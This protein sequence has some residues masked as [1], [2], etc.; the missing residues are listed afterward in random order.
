MQKRQEIP[1]GPIP[2][3]RRADEVPVKWP[4]PTRTR[5]WHEP[6]VKEGPT[7]RPRAC[8]VPSKVLYK[9]SQVPTR[10]CPPWALR[11]VNGQPGAN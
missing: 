5:S 6:Q 10:K 9:G 2:L 3:G 8:S 1:A 7:E 11:F 4:P